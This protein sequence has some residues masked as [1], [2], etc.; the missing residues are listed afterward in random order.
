MPITSYEKVD[1]E[2]NVM[3]L[4]ES[5]DIMHKLVYFQ[6]DNLDVIEEAICTSNQDIERGVTTIEE[7]APIPSWKYVVGTIGAFGVSGLLTALFFLL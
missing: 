3:L 2:R 4:K 5:M 1:I 6:G 7:S